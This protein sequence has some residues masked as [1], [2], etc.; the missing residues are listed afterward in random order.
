MNKILTILKENKH[1]P[2]SSS[3]LE[4][5]YKYYQECNYSN[6]C[7]NDISEDLGI[8]PS[9]L[10][11][12]IYSYAK[13]TLGKNTKE[14][15]EFRIEQRS[16]NMDLYLSRI[17]IVLEKHEI[18]TKY[19][20]NNEE[21][22]EIFLKDIYNYSSKNGFTEKS[23]KEMAKNI[24]ISTS[25][26]LYLIKLY[27]NE[28]LNAS[29]KDIEEKTNYNLN[30]VDR[31][32]ISDDKNKIF[33]LILDSKDYE[34][35]KRIINDSIYSAGVL[36]NDFRFYEKFYSEEQAHIIKEKI[37]DYQTK[38]K[39]ELKEMRQFYKE[40]KIRNKIIQTKNEVESLIN[41]YISS[42]DVSTFQFLKINNI[43]GEEFEEKVKALENIN[44][45]LYNEYKEIYEYRKIIDKEAIKEFQNHIINGFEVDGKVR[46]FDLLDYYMFTN[47]PLSKMH[48]LGVD[49]FKRAARD[50]LHSFKRSF[51]DSN[52]EVLS[53]IK[54][55]MEEKR[56]IGFTKDERGNLVMDSA[57][58][59]KKS[60][61]ELVINFLQDNNL[62][63]NR[64]TINI[65]FRRYIN[66]FLNEKDPKK[67]TLNNQ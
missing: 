55:F 45:S 30:S 43:T 58:E 25:K 67:L 64:I 35:V 9:I 26:Y 48:L 22:K 28:Y 61:K 54:N 63:I 49:K 47:I 66:G 50:K 33:K 62:P 4:S 44:P 39:K 53:D 21:Q 57:R 5:L 41:D 14:F 2:T 31:K 56:T 7:F 38:R 12:Y 18:E 8:R 6:K 16:K 42:K 65:C 3:F 46:N 40:R 52:K 24:G 1:D 17:N 27:M 13:N 51:K 36:N 34:D 37:I 11:S 10:K 19:L 60:E 20:W 29:Q 59:V 15:D 32:R 23:S